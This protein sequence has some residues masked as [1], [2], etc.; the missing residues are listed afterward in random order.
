MTLI[1]SVQLISASY[2]TCIPF[3]NTNLNGCHFMGIEGKDVQ[4]HIQMSLIFTV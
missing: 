4:G 3:L 2:T 1:T